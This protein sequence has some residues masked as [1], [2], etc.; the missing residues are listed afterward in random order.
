MDE[1]IRAILVPALRGNPWDRTRPPAQSLRVQG[2]SKYVAL[3]SVSTDPMIGM[4]VQLPALRPRISWGGPGT[5]GDITPR[6]TLMANKIEQI[7]GGLAPAPAAE[8]LQHFHRFNKSVS[9]MQLRPLEKG[10]TVQMQHIMGK[11][12]APSAEANK[13]QARD[14]VA[15]AVAALKDLKKKPRDSASREPSD[16]SGPRSAGLGAAYRWL[17]VFPQA[18]TG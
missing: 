12:P 17:R 8:E 14:H 7:R 10:P 11:K 18:A 3:R 16:G 6:M 9:S 5:P 1:T 13:A 15:F 2:N 4:R